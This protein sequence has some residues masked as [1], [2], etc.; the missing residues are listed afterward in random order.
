MQ[1]RIKIKKKKRK[2][3]KTDF[4]FLIVETTNNQQE[5]KKVIGKQNLNINKFNKTSYNEI[6]N[7][8]H[9]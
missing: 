6:K 9:K 7:M 4:S 3:N 2:I 8:Q 5:H 1:I